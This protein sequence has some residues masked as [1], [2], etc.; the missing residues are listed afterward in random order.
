MR[1][2][3]CGYENRE[4]NRFCQGCGADLTTSDSAHLVSISVVPDVLQIGQ[5]RDVELR[6]TNESREI[7][8]DIIFSAKDLKAVVDPAEPRETRLLPG[9][10]WTRK[11][12]IEVVSEL[13]RLR[14]PFR[15][16]WRNEIGRAGSHQG[17]LVFAV[18]P[19]QPPPPMPPPLTEPPDV[20]R[21]IN[22]AAVRDLLTAAFSDEEFT[23][24]CFDHFRPVYMQFSTG[25]SMPQ[26]IQRLI[27]YCERKLLF[28][29]LLAAVRERNQVQFDRFEA[30]LKMT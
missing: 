13:K 2:P 26:K 21:G 30:Q 12:A 6:V 5:A 18:E 23:I 20:E 11:L 17:E 22:T 14:L 19:R 4:N 28:D 25:M 15:L 7:F 24:L 8:R 1:C 9:E 10:T 29:R 27:E 16:R 3:S